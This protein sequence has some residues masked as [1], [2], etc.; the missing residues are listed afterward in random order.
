MFLHPNS[1]RVAI[2]GREEGSTLCK[3]LNR[4][5]VIDAKMIEI[6]VVMVNVSREYLLE[7][8]SCNDI[9]GLVSNFFKDPWSDMH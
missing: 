9:V 4:D 6:D 5:T 7:R 3:V 8:N 1:Y 2:I